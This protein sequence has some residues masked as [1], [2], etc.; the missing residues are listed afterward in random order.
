MNFLKEIL[1]EK[2][3]E[4]ARLSGDPGVETLEALARKS[5]PP[6]D[7]HAALQGDIAIISEV[8]R[9]SPS[10]GTLMDGGDPGALAALYEEH[11]A[12]AVSVLTDQRFFSGH[13]ED[14]GTVKKRV[15]LPVLRKDFIIDP[16][17]VYESRAAGADAVLLIVRILEDERLRS[18][19]LLTQ[20]LGM[21]PLVEV[22]TDGELERALRAGATTVGI[23]NRDLG[24]FT[25]DLETGK[26]LLRRVPQGVTAI[27]ESGIMGE[28]DIAALAEAGFRAFLVGEALVTS[29]APG[30]TLRQL[31]DAARRA[32]G[33]S[34]PCS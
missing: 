9:K 31:L 12:R 19:M 30:N 15:S 14:L 29:P 10:K 11:G 33:S 2:K 16:I 5:R 34:S 24:T 28:K 20:N 7:F 27:A 32:A 22:H 26:R 23:N 13:T 21:T 4:V 6:R 1:E 18:L 8:K 25:V 17:Q 3:R